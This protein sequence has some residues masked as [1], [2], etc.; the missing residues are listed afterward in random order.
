[1]AY[2]DFEPPSF[3]LGL[4]LETQPDPLPQ[5]AKRPS[6]SA[7][8]RE[9][10]E[11]DDNDD[12]KTPIR[13]T[14]QSCDFKR[15][16][17]GPKVVRPAHEARKAESIG[18]LFDVI[19]EIEDFSSDEDWP[20][21]RINSVCS[22]SKPSL[23]H[24]QGVVT[25]ESGTQFKS[26]KAKEV[27]YVSASKNVEI[28]GGKTLNPKLTASPVRRYQLINSDSDSDDPSMI[29]DP[30]KEEPVVKLSLPKDEHPNSRFSMGMRR[31]STGKSKSEDLWK[32]FPSDKSLR[33]PTPAF[34]EL[35][36]EYFDIAKNKSKPEIV[37][38]DSYNETKLDKPT[39]PPARGYFFHKDLRVQKLVRDRLPYFFPLGVENNKEYEQQNG[40]AI[41]YLGQF[42]HEGTKQTN[43][44]RNMEKSSRGKGSKRPVKQSH[45]ESVSEASTSWVNPRT[46]A[47]LQKNGGSRRVQAVS[48]S[49]GHWYTG[50]DGKR[51]Y[52]NK[53]GKELTG[54]I[55][56][57]HYKKESGMGFKTSKKKNSA[58]KK[59]AANKSASKKK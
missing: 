14:D 44:K 15:L 53:Q 45:V 5:P 16:R 4:D 47:G 19:E 59:A 37:C 13:V 40:V 10:E 32:D 33:V 58:T 36:E 56:Y 24:R 31:E 2:Y 18:G 52:V 51:V 34:D 3:S 50:P 48:K 6:T 55:A 11:D 12:F 22:S 27:P 21:G 26:N 49:A 43:Q 20:R 28:N 8:S 9:L 35:L 29:Q 30:P 17:R 25:T 38:K 54:Q 7:S 39:L 57:R 41:D 1:M 42:C 46:C 23:L